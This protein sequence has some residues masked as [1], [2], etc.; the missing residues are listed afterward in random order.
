MLWRFIA[1]YRCA[2]LHPGVIFLSWHPASVG[3]HPVFREHEKLQGEN[4]MRAKLLLL[5]NERIISDTLC[6][7]LN[8][9]GYNAIAAYNGTDAAA[10]AK[11]FRPDF[12]FCDVVMP[13]MNG[14]E[15]A[16]HV[17]RLSPEC[18]I[19]F[20]SGMDPIHFT[21]ENYPVLKEYSHP[22]KI[23][24]S[25]IRPEDLIEKLKSDYGLN[26]EL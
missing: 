16:L 23:I 5:A 7:I 12:L 2:D 26:P 13:E 17:K 22:V 21:P 15:A 19:L 25:P 4:S 14:F 11:D 9:Q 1:S 24:P 10:K 6:I 8:S 20:F 18:Q 3:P